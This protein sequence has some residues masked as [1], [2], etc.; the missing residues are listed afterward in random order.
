MKFYIRATGNNRYAGGSFRWLKI[1]S[2][3]RSQSGI[4]EIGV[5]IKGNE[6]RTAVSAGIHPEQLEFRMGAWPK[7][8]PVPF[9]TVLKTWESKDL[10]N[11]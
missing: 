6:M 11:K 1:R 10:F 7:A 4:Y 2:I 5:K 9:S 8:I 3:A